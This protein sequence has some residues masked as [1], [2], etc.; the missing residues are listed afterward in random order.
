MDFITAWYCDTV[1]YFRV[2]MNLVIS[3][4]SWT[5][6]KVRFFFSQPP[7]HSKS[8]IQLPDH[9]CCQG[10]PNPI[11]AAWSYYPMCY[12]PSN[13]SLYH[14]A[15]IAIAAQ[16]FGLFSYKSQPMR[17]FHPTVMKQSLGEWA[18]TE[19][20]DVLVDGKQTCLLAFRWKQ[21]I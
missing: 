13:C 19:G 3:R 21:V 2:Q 16:P 6:A 11:L 14:P 5:T 18:S 17:L 20:S 15:K 8:S 7:H 1:K 10:D 9:N 4:I 12:F